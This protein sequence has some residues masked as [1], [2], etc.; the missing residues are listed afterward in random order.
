MFGLICAIVFPFYFE[1][2]KFRGWR[3]AFNAIYGPPALLKG[4]ELQISMVSYA[5]LARK[6]F[7][8][9]EIVKIRIK[10]LE[11]TSDVSIFIQEI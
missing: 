3:F 4:R 10:A 11:S 1:T 6:A 5:I 9:Q 7:G 2:C 8:L